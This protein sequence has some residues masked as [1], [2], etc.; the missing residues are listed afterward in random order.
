[1]WYQHSGATL[2]VK[3]RKKRRGWLEILLLVCL[4]RFV[5]FHLRSLN[6]ISVSSSL[7]FSSRK[8]FLSLF[9]FFIFYFES[10]LFSRFS[11]S[12][13]FVPQ[14]SLLLNQTLIP[15]LGFIYFYLPVF[16][17]ADYF[18]WL[19][20]H[21]RL[22]IHSVRFSQLTVFTSIF[23]TWHNHCEIVKLYIYDSLY[24]PLAKLPSSKE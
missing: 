23:I 14:W 8:Q 13:V 19:R 16:S 15:N 17:A 24:N 5:I 20:A 7:F 18:P 4:V 21:S 10:S 12:I 6:T 22:N 3:L 11:I 9:F 1:M 2:G